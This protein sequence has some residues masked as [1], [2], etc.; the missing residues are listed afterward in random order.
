MSTKD[1]TFFVEA[2]LQK[3]NFRDQKL[4]GLKKKINNVTT[5]M[6]K[7]Y[8]QDFHLPKKIFYF[9]LMKAF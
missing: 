9:A 3:K 7:R 5:G 8:V 2:F 4:I 6:F 1:Y